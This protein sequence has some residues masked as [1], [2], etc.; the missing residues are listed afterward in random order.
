MKVR[1]ASQ[2]IERLDDEL[3][4]R[5]HEIASLRDAIR[6]SSPPAQTALIR[7]AVAL[8]YAH[9]EGFVKA[10]AVHYGS[11]ISST[12][13]T[14][15]EAHLSFSGLKALGH[16]KQLHAINKRVFVA[17]ELLS[18]L[19]GIETEKVTLPLHG[20]ISQ[21]VIRPVRANSTVLIY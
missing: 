13:I 6:R 3:A 11:Y 19:Q 9:W 16:V 14:F 20:Y 21:L 18:E 5:L 4:W 1:T 7:S 12:G 2:L 17:S 10:A 15:S 8:L